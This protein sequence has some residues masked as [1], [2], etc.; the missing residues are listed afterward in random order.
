MNKFKNL[1]FIAI[2]L[3]LA[4][5]CLDDD[6]GREEIPT[7]DAEEVRLENEIDIQTFLESHY[8]E[9]E[10]E[11]G[12]PNFEKI[13]FK[14]LDSPDAPQDVI[15]LSEVDELT[16]KSVTRDDVNYDLY[17]LKLR[18][19]AA[20][21]RKPFFADSV[22]VTY[23]GYNIENNVFD[24]SPTPLWIDLSGTIVGFR[25]AFTEHRGASGFVENP[26][27]T[28][29]FN[30]DYGTG[31][32]IIPSGLA[33]FNQ[34]PLNSN[35]GTYEPIIFS[36]K[37]FRSRVID[38]DSDGIPSHLE[39]LNNTRELSDDDTDEDRVPNFA[40][41]D[42]DGDG[43]PTIDEISIDDE[44]NVS[45]PDTNGNGTADYLDPTYPTN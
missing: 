13:V 18:E 43:V 23:Q 1:L 7:R 27:G 40:D 28:I 5:S 20:T 12:N 3:S 35:I 11:S 34:P 9:V 8:Y 38:H 44:G 17:I 33:Y 15:P 16:T 45:F 30:D 21:E 24:G 26:D 41:S 4:V 22:L 32:V 36:Y 14:R 6:N 19:G 42:D 10:N 39:D 29:A 37:L 25:E 31:A 2:F